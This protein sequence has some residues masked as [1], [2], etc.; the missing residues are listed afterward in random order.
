MKKFSFKSLMAGALALAMV[1]TAMPTGMLTANAAGTD[2]EKVYRSYNPNDSEHLYTTNAAEHQF[3]VAQGRTDEGVAWIAPKASSTEVYRAYNPNTGEHLLVPKSEAEGL[4]ALY[5]WNNEGCKM[6]SDDN[7]GVPVYRVYN[8]NSKDAGSHHYTSNKAEA[9]MLVAQGWSWDNNGQPV[10]YGVNEEI[11]EELA[12]ESVEAGVAPSAAGR[13]NVVIAYFNTA[14][15]DLNASDVQI[16]QVSNDQLFSVEKVVMSSDK[17]TATLTLTNTSAA[18]AAVQG[19]EANVDYN[20][21]VTT[22]TGKATKVFSIPAV[23]D[24]AEVTAIDPVKKTIDA[25]TFGVGAAGAWD[26][27][28]TYNIPDE[29]NLDYN[30]ALGQTITIKYDKTNTALSATLKSDEKVIYGAFKE[31]NVSATNYYLQ[32]CLTETKYYTQNAVAGTIPTSTDV[33]YTAIALPAAY[34]VAAPWGAGAVGTNAEYAYG[35]LVLNTNGTIKNFLHLSTW[36]GN[37]YVSKISGNS[38]FSKTNQEQSLENFAIIKDGKTIDIT[39]IKENDVVF[40]STTAK[41]AVVYND[42]RTGKIEAVYDDAGFK[43]AGKDYDGSNASYINNG[44]LAGV[45]TKYLKSL[46]TEKDVTVIFNH[47]NVPVYVLGEQSE[48]ATS[49]V[50]LVL[51]KKGDGFSQTTSNY[52]RL[53]GFN[54]VSET[55]EDID[56][57][58]IES[59]TVYSA[60]NAKK[61][62]KS[63]N[64]TFTATKASTNG[65][66]DY[67]TATT[68]EALAFVGNDSTGAA[69]TLAA[70]KVTLSTDLFVGKMVSLTKNA[71]GVVTDITIPWT[72][73]V[74]SGANTF[75]GANDKDFKAGYTSI[76]AF[77]IAG[78][79]PVFTVSDGPEV[80][81][82]TYSAFDKT[83][84]LAN[85]GCIDYYLADSGNIGAIVIDNQNGAAFSDDSDGSTTTEY[86]VKDVKYLDGKISSLSVIKSGS[87]KTFSKFGDDSSLKSD[88]GKGDVINVKVLKDGVT[89]STIDTTTYPLGTVEDRIYGVS[90]SAPGSFYAQVSTAGAEH[91]VKYTLTADATLVKI[92][93]NTVSAIS[94][95]DLKS[96]SLTK[97]VSVSLQIAGGDKADAVVVSST[98]ATQTLAA[99]LT[100]LAAGRAGTGYTG[101]VGG[102]GSV[103]TTAEYDQMK[104]AK[105][106]LEIVRDDMALAMSTADYEAATGWGSTATANAN[107]N[108][109]YATLSDEL[110]RAAKYQ[111]VSFSAIEGTKKAVAGGTAAATVLATIKEAL[112]SSIHATMADGSEKDITVSF[113][114]AANVTLNGADDIDLKAINTAG[115]EAVI[116]WALDSATLNADT[117]AGATIILQPQADTAGNTYVFTGKNATAEGT[118]NV[119]TEGIKVATK[120]N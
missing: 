73:D 104:A 114:T 98:A 110:T 62:Y 17:K 53:V 51:T 101:A 38:I 11:T 88:I 65:A 107:G 44:A 34:G 70:D 83:I 50:N 23:A 5:G 68:D 15:G 78:T 115:S 36:S 2:T 69:A 47:A 27:V 95:S 37:I 72:V 111:I 32:D 85:V 86:V 103:T 119:T 100:D 67:G 57:S 48:I 10:L 116:S 54:G 71:K 33:D 120:M 93:N 7:K 108:T 97:A 89:V 28:A 55:T 63:T 18:G 56:I 29:L 14:V 112:P 19:L 106:D 76:D 24:N 102:A 46:G 49:S 90:T 92:E 20:L 82:T 21:I 45:T 60:I 81:L 26:A 77:T 43:F 12:L 9:E 8:P 99:T 25:R 1:V 59:L 94:L 87:E 84:A 113:N 40:Y 91:L 96:L 74:V 109:I 16:R 42:V 64:G 31:V 35:K 58:K 80:A 22:A 39:D 118:V 79:T 61:T 41:L 6:Y 66:Q 52:V 4:A 117:V 13:Y 3:V 75:N 105:K 30:L